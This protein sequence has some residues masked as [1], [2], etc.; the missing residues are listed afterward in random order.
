L[1]ADGFFGFGA[2]EEAEEEAEDDDMTMGP[3]GGRGKSIT[4]SDI[5]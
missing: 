1:G 2:A 5:A 4:D 3:V